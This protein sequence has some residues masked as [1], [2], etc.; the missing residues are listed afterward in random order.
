[1]NKLAP[2]STFELDRPTGGPADRIAAEIAALDTLDLEA[3]RAEWRRLY[4]H[5]APKF[6][7]R[8]LL[9]RGIAYEMQAKVFG[10]LSPKTRKK[11]LK[12]AADHEAGPGF[13]TADAPRKLRPGTRLIRAWKGTTHTVNVLDDGFEWSGQKFRSLSA[14][15]R[16][17]SGTNWNGF[18]FFGLDRRKGGDNV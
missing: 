14:I 8:N 4:R 5:P 11:L 1:V 13:T 10:G 6:F 18:N 2:A 16:E 17:I 15:A 12:I 7:R 9:I 3:L